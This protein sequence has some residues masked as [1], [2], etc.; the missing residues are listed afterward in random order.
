MAAHVDFDEQVIIDGGLR[1]DMVVR[2]WRACKN[3]VVDSKVSLAA[4]P[5]GH[6][7]GR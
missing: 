4:Y 1:P 7:D 6:V 3:V 5:G 2:S